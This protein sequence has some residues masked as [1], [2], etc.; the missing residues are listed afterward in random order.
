MRALG[1]DLGSRRVGVAISDREGRVVTP[2]LTLERAR[3]RATDHRAIAELV[4]E[5][6]IEIVVV[7][8]PL[9]LDGSIG[10]AARA[11]LDEVDVLTPQLGVPVDTVDE[12]FS[13]V[14]A[15]QQLRDAGVRGRNK[16]KVIDQAAAVVL[17]QAWLE[18]KAAT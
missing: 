5:Y 11:I 8:L 14:E 4:D 13:T 3:D 2:L 7:G 17:L 18:R 10:P 1:L 9:S 12:R 15:E 16:T 6:D